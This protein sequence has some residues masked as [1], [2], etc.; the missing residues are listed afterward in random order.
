[1]DNK[2][3]HKRFSTLF[4]WTLTVFPWLFL[5]ITLVG[6]IVNVYQESAYLTASELSSYFY[7]TFT[8]FVNGSAGFQMFVIPQV[9]NAFKSLFTNLG[10]NYTGFNYL[11]YLLGWMVS[12]QLYHLIFDVICWIF[13]WCHSLMERSYK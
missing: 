5:L 12:I 1:M 6:A 8:G 4:W 10:L 9:Y 2:K 13:W 11:P 7:A 3:W